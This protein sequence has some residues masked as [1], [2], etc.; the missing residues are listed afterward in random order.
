MNKYLII[1][2]I[3]I[4]FCSI[5]NNKLKIIEQYDTN[6][7]NDTNNVDDKCNEEDLKYNPDIWNNKYIQKSHNCYNY[8]FNNI[9]LDQLQ[10]SK[11][12]YDNS[13]NKD[14]L[15]Q[16][17]GISFSDECENKRLCCKSALKELQEDHPDMIIL[18]GINKDICPDDY[19]KAGLLI[20]DNG[21]SFHFLR[22]D[23]CNN[24]NNV[25]SHK[26]AYA[27]VT[28]GDK[29]NN[30]FT[31]LKEGNF[32]YTNTHGENANY[33]ELCDYFCVKTKDLPIKEI[34]KI[35]N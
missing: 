17:G 8:A 12:W 18:N 20:S 27:K 33:N 9:N 28:R 35:I 30:E 5:Y 16:K 4:I 10:K 11:N 2:L 34:N 24:E 7:I 23:E 29:N 6:N 32:D 1:L 26:N 3:I 25:W 31:S 22:E 14:L 13:D 21:K 15:K 19:H